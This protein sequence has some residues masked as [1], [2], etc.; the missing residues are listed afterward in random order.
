[1]S[2][3]HNSTLAKAE[4][5]W[6]NVDKTKLP[7]NAYADM[8]DVGLKSSWRYPHHHIADGT[9]GGKHGVF[10]K[11]D[12]FLHKGGL[13]A[14]LQAAGGA[15]SGKKESNPAVKR[16]LSHHADVIDMSKKETASLLGISIDSLKALLNNNNNNDN[17][18]TEKQR[19]GGE[20]L[21]SKT[22][23]DLEAEVKDL[24]TSLSEKDNAIAVM[25]ADA[26]TAKANIES[27]ESEITKYEKAEGDLNDKVDELGK[28]AK[29]N[30]VYIEAGKTAI[31]DMKAEICKLSAQVDGKDYN[32]ELVDKQ[33]EAFG[34]DVSALTQFKQN[35]EAR[36]TKLFKT[37]ELEPDEAANPK[38]QKK[39]SASS[40]QEL[41]ASIVPAGLRLVK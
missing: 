39:G 3:T 38:E 22:Y 10:I 20:N 2:L 32:K 24:K 14:A 35:L 41:G 36:R 25:E 8:G 12:M 17:D 6:G 21:M 16:H 9:I 33:L 13:K 30:V 27:L 40:D 31:E 15:R 5:S 29:G 26:K 11:G 18:S 28:E 37:G 4:P 19:G 1:M 23:E 34:T 7:R